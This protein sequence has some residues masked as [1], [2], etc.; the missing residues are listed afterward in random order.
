MMGIEEEFVRDIRKMVQY[1][2]FVI[3]IVRD[4]DLDRLSIFR[5]FIRNKKCVSFVEIVRRESVMP[6][7]SPR[8][9]VIPSP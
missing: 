5:G 9:L 4:A 2:G 1:V 8:Y 7:K 6:Q 3:D